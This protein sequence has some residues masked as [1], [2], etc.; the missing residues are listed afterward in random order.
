M[1][2]QR[3]A[4][5]TLVEVLVALLIMA[6]LAT[7][8]WRGIDALLRTRDGAQ[9]QTEQMLR[10]TTV[11]AQWEQDLAHVQRSGVV[12]AL[13]FDGAALRL[14]RS[15]P[16]GVQLVVW[17]LQDGQLWRWASPALTRL[18]PLRE[19]AARS[20]QWALIGPQALRMLGDVSQWQV[21][22]FQ[23]GD[24]SWSNAQSTGNRRGTVINGQVAVPPPGGASGA[25]T[26]N[27]DDNDDED[28]N[29]GANAQADADE[30]LP[31]GVRLV[32][33]L[34]AGPLTRDLV[35]SPAP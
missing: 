30:D 29:P 9:A 1:L 2:R 31:V 22:Y 8:A 3:H 28:N 10:L 12:P 20:Q 19:A 11:L 33:S 23:Q 18:A 14:T 21:F 16:E 26:G 15:T 7:L 27:D 17:T 4:G 34:P 35:L 24:G 25:G 13:R 6:V 5:F 32:L